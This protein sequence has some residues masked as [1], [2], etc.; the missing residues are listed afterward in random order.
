[1]PFPYT[2]LVLHEL[3]VHAH[4][5]RTS[6]TYSYTNSGG[7]K[8]CC[9]SVVLS[10]GHIR[11]WQT[12]EWLLCKRLSCNLLLNTYI[13]RS[14]IGRPNASW[15]LKYLRLEIFKG[16]KLKYFEGCAMKMCSGMCTR[17]LG[18]NVFLWSQM[19]ILIT[20]VLDWL[21]FVIWILNSWINFLCLYLQHITWA[22]ASLALI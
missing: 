9:A 6:S 2:A 5:R 13:L 4:G 7:D 20:H 1:M 16:A 8:E 18:T 10:W 22:Y 12:R 17:A 15:L 11:G 19:C 14:I 21:F 3:L